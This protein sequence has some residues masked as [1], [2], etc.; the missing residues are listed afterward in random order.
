MQP[1]KEYSRK[2]A[3]YELYKLLDPQV[4]HDLIVALTKPQISKKAFQRALADPNDAVAAQA[5]I[6][7]KD[8][9]EYMW[10]TDYG[11]AFKHCGFEVVE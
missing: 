10:V 6:D 11:P 9:I 5:A 1:Q 2:E 8:L 7:H 3:E 4:A